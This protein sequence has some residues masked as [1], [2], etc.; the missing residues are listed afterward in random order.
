MTHQKLDQVQ[1]LTNIFRRGR[2]AC[3][4]ITKQF[5]LSGNIIIQTERLK[6]IHTENKV[7][8]NYKMSEIINE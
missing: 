5:P 1:L 8:E 7:I 3:L 6:F 2:K 4:H